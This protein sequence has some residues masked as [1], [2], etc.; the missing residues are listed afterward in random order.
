MLSIVILYAYNVEAAHRPQS[1]PASTSRSPPRL[2]PTCRPAGCNAGD[3][4]P[5]QRELADALGVTV[6]TVTRGYAE[7][8]RLRAGERRSRPRHLRPAAGLCAAARR[9]SRASSISRTNALL[10]QAH[11]GELVAALAALVARTDP[12]SL[13]NY[14]PHAGLPEHRAVAA[15]FLHEHAACP[16]TRATPSSPPARSMRWRSRSSTLTAPGETVLCEA[17]TY[18]GMRSLA[19]SPARAAAGRG[20]GRR[21]AAARRAR[22]RRA[23]VRRP[24]A[25]LHAVGAEPDRRA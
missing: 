8:E 22:G 20:H 25:L 1:R 2:P 19:Q 17:V 5:P 10:P 12:Q 14:Q 9:A 24:R 18:T 11:A 7:A 3:R 6:T 4:L 16:P 15:A 13:F 23:R 21:R